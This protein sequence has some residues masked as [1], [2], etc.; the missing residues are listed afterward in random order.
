M[1]KNI[2][3]KCLVRA[4]C[5][6]RV[7]DVDYR[8]AKGFILYYHPMSSTVNSIILVIIKNVILKSIS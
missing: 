3:E 8:L 7:V 1:F 2:M 5:R 6:Y 4:N